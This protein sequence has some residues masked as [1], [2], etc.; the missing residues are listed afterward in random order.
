[1]FIFAAVASPAWME[2]VIQIQIQTEVGQIVKA[3]PIVIFLVSFCEI[4][5]KILPQVLK[6]EGQREKLKH[7]TVN[8]ELVNLTHEIEIFQPQFASSFEEE[9]TDRK[10]EEERKEGGNT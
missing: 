5:A 7:E 9:R 3:R 2:K 4:T 1:M 10:L 6:G 8:C